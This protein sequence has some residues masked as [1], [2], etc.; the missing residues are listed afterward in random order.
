MDRT[1]AAFEQLQER[2]GHAL[3][4][5]QPGRDDDHVLVALP[6]FSIG[7]S[8]L[9]HYADRLPALEHRYLIAAL[10]LNR[11]ACDCVLVVSQAP[12]AEV[13]DYYFSL[14]PE[15]HRES[16]RARLH[17]L[18]VPDPSHR[19]VAAKLLDREDLVE[20]LRSVIGGR[21]AFIE[22]WNVTDDEVAVA[23][24]LDAPINGSA[25]RL[26]PLG[27]KSA[28]RRL[29]KEAGVPVPAGCE[30][31]RDLD[32]VLAAIASVRAAR[33]NVAGV[34]IKHDDSGAGDGNQV[35]DLR[36]PGDLR[37]R[38]EALPA[39][40]LDDL[41]DGAVVEELISGT[42]FTTPSVQI[43]V[44]PDRRVVV[45]ATHE[46]VMGGTGGQV[47]M[48]CRFPADGAYA[49]EL[50][51]HGRAVGERLAEHGVLGRAS[52]DFAAARDARGRWHLYALEVNLR[53]GGTTHPYAVL[54]NLAPGHYDEAAGRWFT[55][56]GSARAYWATDNLVDP[57]W[58]GVAPGA[59]IDAV[60][61]AGLQFD[62]S[63]GTGVVLHMLS[64]L[65]IDGRLGLTAIGRSPD[66]AAEL[67]EA[68]GVAI[69]T[70]ADQAPTE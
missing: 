52:V 66:H 51:R 56:D 4:L 68:A 8:L 32:G 25:P 48:G 65:A 47:Y 62:P 57:A 1:H 28:G 53:K 70:A 63:R 9:S 64:C 36:T 22:P 20:E 5:S 14:M 33:P 35:V 58:T 59:V 38:L 11:I 12:T 18:E 17:V 29:F 26:W 55:A 31:V 3:S 6:S 27:F 45:L 61:A 21:P 49:G 10:V 50:A 37:S 42:R 24:A 67:Y 16:A 19:S 39:W 23:L 54:R 15:A 30:G 60:A 69:S 41:A 2:L 34:V 7:E 44:L 40:Y 43:D 13:L 46:Q